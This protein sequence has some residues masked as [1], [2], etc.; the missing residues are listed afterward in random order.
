MCGTA[1]QPDDA[2][3]A[4]WEGSRYRVLAA[5]AAIARELRGQPPGTPVTSSRQLA[6]ALD[7]PAATVDRAKRFLAAQGVIAK[8]E[9][10]NRYYTA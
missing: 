6:P 8:A 4:Q 3:L 10:S 2:A 1:P 9:G 7:V 5:A